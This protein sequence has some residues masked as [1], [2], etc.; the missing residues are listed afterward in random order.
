MTDWAETGLGERWRRLHPG[1]RTAA[2]FAIAAL[3]TLALPNPLVEGMS[4]GTGLA[5]LAP[6]VEPPIG[7]VG[8]LLLA[9][10]VGWA[11]AVGYALWGWS[12]A[13]PPAGPVEVRVDGALVAD[14]PLRV[15]ALA[16]DRDLGARFD[17]SPYLA[18]PPPTPDARLDPDSTLAD[19]RWQSGT[20]ETIEQTDDWDR[21][22]QAHWEAQADAVA[23][24]QDG[25]PEPVE[26][27]EPGNGAEQWDGPAEIADREAEVGP[28]DAP[29]EVETQALSGDE[30][31][32]FD[33]HPAD[34]V[35]EPAAAR[36]VPAI[37]P[38]KVA[39]ASLAATEQP[40][41]WTA[42]ARRLLPPREPSGEPLPTTA[43]LLDRLT[44]AAVRRAP[45]PSP[46]R[47]GGADDPAAQIAEAL[48]ILR[49]AG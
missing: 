15:E 47:A 44:R 5:R 45:R 16:A 28:P 29:E 34:P 18:P 7:L 38:P 17:E 12:R 30:V 27:L 48:Q 10:V 20:A 35:M 3:L 24:E 33:P 49:R 19:P 36:D 25:L 9:L 21:S 4:R 41:D 37:D 1:W 22:V 40:D 43:E 32:A 14:D 13:R 8:R 11:A 46:P 2:V 26:P 31:A 39:A 23:A 42:L 6:P